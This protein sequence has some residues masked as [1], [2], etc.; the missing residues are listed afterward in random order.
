M[1]TKLHRC[2]PAA[3][4]T[5][6]TTPVQ[7]FTGRTETERAICRPMGQFYCFGL[8]CLDE[9]Q[10]SGG[11][12]GSSG[13]SCSNPDFIV[14]NAETL[15]SGLN[16]LNRDVLTLSCGIKFYTDKT[17]INGYPRYCELFLYHRYLSLTENRLLLPHLYG[18]CSK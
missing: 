12:L 7:F 8:L 1:T 11:P 17:D 4:I 15:N 9:I 6:D 13:N 14:Q 10:L 2:K 18:K 5:V 3:Q 16:N